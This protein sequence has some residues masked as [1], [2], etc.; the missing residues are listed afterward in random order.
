MIFKC[1]KPRKG[2]SLVLA[3]FLVALMAVPAFALYEAPNKLLHT[4]VKANTS[5]TAKQETAVS[6]TTIIPQY[7]RI[8]GYT[9]MPYDTTK[10]AELWIGLYDDATNAATSTDI[11]DE[12]EQGQS[13]YKAPI[14]YPYPKKL[15]DGLVFL[16]G[17]NSV[18]VIYYEDTREF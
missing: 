14:W 8:I 7:C 10:N 11:F 6:V 17:M 16:Q 3:L 9:I 13:N 2:L 12:A 5:G 18:V 1:K 4:Y 15:T